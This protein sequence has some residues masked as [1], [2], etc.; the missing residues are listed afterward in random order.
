MIVRC[1]VKVWPSGD[2]HWMPLQLEDKG[3][4]IKSLVGEPAIFLVMSDGSRKDLRKEPPFY[5]PIPCPYCGVEKDSNHDP[6]QHL[7][8]D[9]RNL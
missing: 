8:G 2:R 1:E 6:M 5:Q 3:K 4:V 7:H 9:P